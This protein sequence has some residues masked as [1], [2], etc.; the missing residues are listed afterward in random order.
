MVEKDLFCSTP[1]VKQEEDCRFDDITIIE[2]PDQRVNFIITC[3]DYEELKF[4]QNF[5][6]TKAKKIEYEQFKNFI[7]GHCED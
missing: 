4:L 6:K 3:E 5:F 2:N 1:L 7:I